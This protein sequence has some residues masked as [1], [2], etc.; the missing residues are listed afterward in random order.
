MGRWCIKSWENRDKFDELKESI[1]PEPTVDAAHIESM[2]EEHGLSDVDDDPDSASL[3]YRGGIP[4]LEM[5]RFV[6]G[7]GLTSFNKRT[8]AAP[9]DKCCGKE[10]QFRV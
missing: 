6:G 2:W 8:L 5:S 9:A 7:D 4:R 3:L 10:D 1:E